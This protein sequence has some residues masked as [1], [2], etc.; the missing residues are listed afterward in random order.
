MQEMMGMPP[1][2]MKE[3]MSGKLGSATSR[4]STTKDATDSKQAGRVEEL[5]ASSD[6]GDEDMETIMKQME[7]ELREQGALN[8]D[9]VLSKTEAMRKTVKGKEEDSDL[10]EDDL[11]DSNIDANLVK[12]LLES[13]KAQA[14]AA[15][16]SGNLMNLMGVN[17][18][19]DEGD[20]DGDNDVAGPSTRRPKQ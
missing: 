4:Q 9:P 11:D 18:P 1:A 13:F 7:T 2:V 3:I 14:G 10:S 6:E 8:L 15:G 17:M 20:G 5:D 16:P 12:N 19:R